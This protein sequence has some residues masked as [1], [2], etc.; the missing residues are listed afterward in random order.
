MECITHDNIEKDVR[1]YSVE[2]LQEFYFEGIA[3]LKSKRDGVNGFSGK[4][5]NFVRFLDRF[6]SSLNNTLVDNMYKY[7][8][9]RNYYLK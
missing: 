2:L 6:Y 9:R 1:Y 8:M 7:A 5:Y 3:L 4:K